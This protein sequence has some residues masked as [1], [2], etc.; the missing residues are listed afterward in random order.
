M[1]LKHT[2]VLINDFNYNYKLQ[3]H[4]YVCTHGESLFR[5]LEQKA[6]F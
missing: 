3:L 2:Y 5:T 1:Y 6:P 4:M